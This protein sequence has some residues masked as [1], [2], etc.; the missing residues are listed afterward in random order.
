[1]NFQNLSTLGRALDGE[2][3]PHVLGRLLRL[4]DPERQ[5]FETLAQSEGL[6]P[7]EVR[8]LAPA[9]Y[10]ASLISAS[11]NR[12][13]AEAGLSV[14]V[15]NTCQRGGPGRQVSVWRLIDEP[16]NDAAA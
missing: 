5:L 9:V 15:S 14:R 7:T 4:T 13:L 3:L 8:T 1:M 16:L 11:L 6:S 10:S 12:K 2:A